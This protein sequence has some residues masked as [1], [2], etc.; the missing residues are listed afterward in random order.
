MK[1]LNK[2]KSTTSNIIFKFFFYFLIPYVLINGII[3][4]LF[5]QSPTINVVANDS[6]NYEENKIKFSI[7]CLLPLSY[8][9][10]YFQNEEI[11]Y[12]KFGD[13]YSVDVSE[14]G[15]YQIKVLAINQSKAETS[16]NIETIDSTPPNIDIDNAIVAGNTLIL[17]VND[18]QTEI[19][20]DKVYATKD[21]GDKID[22]TYIDKV[23]GTVQFQ[24]E[25]GEKIVVH[26]EDMI[27]NSAE[28]SFTLN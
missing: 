27:G 4:F 10:T 26:I 5:I 2:N 25:S 3:F 20:Y 24:V 9:K 23:S 17:S 8:I 21:N 16:V 22:A 1:R 11:P 19:N 14:N 7:E 18:D 12:T 6:Q 13:Y 15:T 28:T